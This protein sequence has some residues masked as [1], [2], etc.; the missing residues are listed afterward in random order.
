MR[1]IRDVF[2]DIHTVAD[3]QSYDWGRVWGSIGASLFAGLSVY[4]YVIRQRD[5]DPIVWS[6]ALG[7]VLVGTGLT[8]L[9]KRET[10]PK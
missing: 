1:L 7:A 3:G 4:T 2:R 5:W 10:E 6:T 8:L 9:A